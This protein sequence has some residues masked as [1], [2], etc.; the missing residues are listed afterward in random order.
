MHDPI[1]IKSATA[2]S[3][4]EAVLRRQADDKFQTVLSKDVARTIREQ[5]SG[6][7]EERRAEVTQEEHIHCQE[8]NLLAPEL[9]FKF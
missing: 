4:F 2:M 8:I 7:H 5:N 1:H 3:R 9:F 6:R